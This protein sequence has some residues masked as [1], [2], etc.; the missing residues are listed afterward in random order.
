MTSDPIADMLTRIRNACRVHHSEV[1]MPASRMKT[2]IA[3][4]LKREGYIDDY[5]VEG[6]GVQR[7]VR[8][9]LKYMGKTA[10]IEGVERVSKPSRRV[11]V[12][13]T[14]IPRVLGGFGITILSTPAGILTGKEAK[15]KNVGGELLC[16]VW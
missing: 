2:Q 4:V 11:Y 7:I 6:E 5:A 14:N 16:N 8:I 13:A 1:T 10:V 3:D 9:A 15:A 12:G